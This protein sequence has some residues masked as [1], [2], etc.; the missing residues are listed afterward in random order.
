MKKKVVISSIVMIITIF[1]CTACNPETGTMTCTMSSYPTDGIT[2][3]STYTAEYKN[4]IVRT[5]ETT[6]QV[7]AEDKDNLEVYE[8]RIQELYQ[9]YQGI[10]YYQ[11]KTEIKGNTLTSTTNI[12]YEKVDTDKLI[13][14]DSD[15]GGIIKNGKVNIDD[16]REMYEQNGCNCKKEG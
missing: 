14:V 1:C 2:L 11:N 13:E 7:T 4:N 6:E 12:N 3:R 8:E 10:D 15:N 5:L 16:L 9:G